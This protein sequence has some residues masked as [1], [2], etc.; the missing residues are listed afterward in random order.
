MG[1]AE[2]F[3][4]L[5]EW[6]K[7]ILIVILIVLSYVVILYIIT[8]ALVYFLHIDISRGYGYGCGYDV[9]QYLMTA[10]KI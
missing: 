1:S 9:P 4:K 5:Y 8:V 6:L 7:T 2:S 10:V 3:V